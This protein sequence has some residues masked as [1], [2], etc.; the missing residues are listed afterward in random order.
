MFASSANM[1]EPLISLRD[2]SVIRG[3]R[4]LLDQVS[5]SIEPGRIVTLIGPNGAGKSTLVKVALG[6]IVP[7]RGHCL[8][9]PGLRIGYMPQNL[10]LDPALPLSVERF[11]Q[12]AA[13]GLDDS[14]IRSALSE[15]GASHTLR[16]PLHSLSGGETQRVLL[17]RA[18][19]RDPQLLVLDEPVQGVDITGQE[20]LYQLIAS[21]RDRLQCGVLLVSH[22]LHL[23]MAATDEVLCLQQHVC[24]QGHPDTV[25]AHPAYLAL[26]GKARPSALA[27]YSHHHQHTHDA[28]GHVHDKPGAPS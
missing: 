19:L 8:R 1:P 11:L 14:R 5:L 18:L 2:V 21:L 26:F 24:C 7:D 22:D 28:C 4:T 17:A 9:Q 25:S 13:Q 16:L 3:D 15:T 23:V 6:L 27:P 10:S 12:L 20:E